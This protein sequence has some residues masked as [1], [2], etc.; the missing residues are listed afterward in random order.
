M[1]EIEFIFAIKSGEKRN[2]EVREQVFG[3]KGNEKK[4]D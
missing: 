2:P 3:P 1:E 4:K